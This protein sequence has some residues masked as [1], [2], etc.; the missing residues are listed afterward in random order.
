MIIPFLVDLTLTLHTCISI[1]G[2][3]IPEMYQL[4]TRGARILVSVKFNAK[5]IIDLFSIKL[6]MATLD[7]KPKELKK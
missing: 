4:I 5:L 1:P 7:I 2:I 3:S 6:D